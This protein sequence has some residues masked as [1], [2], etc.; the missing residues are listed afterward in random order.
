VFTVERRDRVRARLLERA[1][2]DPRIVA[3]AA[4]EQVQELAAG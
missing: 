2:A 3:G 1:E 4:A